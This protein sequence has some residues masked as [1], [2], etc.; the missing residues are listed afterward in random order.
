MKS[1]KLALMFLMVVLAFPRIGACAP[2]YGTAMPQKDKFFSGFQA[3]RVLDKKLKNDQG[4]MRSTQGLY[5]LSWGVSDRFCLDGKIG[6]GGLRQQPQ[7]SEQ[8]AYKAWFSGGYGFRMQLLRRDLT[9]IVWGFQH[10]STHPRARQVDGA[11]H[12]AIMDDWQVSFLASRCFSRFVPYAGL[13]LGRMDY[14]H[15]VEQLGH[16]VRSDMAR[17]LSGILGTDFKV[18][19]KSWINLEVQ[20]PNGTAASISYNF[21]L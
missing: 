8:I 9:K 6:V 11:K 18:S 14:I 20:A 7:N 19:D 12:K 13:R 3:H 4:S 17:S 10:I 5:L 21:K 1:L 16:R 2:C 15:W